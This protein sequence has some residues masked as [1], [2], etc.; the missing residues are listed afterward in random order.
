MAGFVAY[1]S[2]EPIGVFYEQKLADPALM[3]VRLIIV[4]RHIYVST[5]IGVAY[6][7]DDDRAFNW[8]TAIAL[9]GLA[10]SLFGNW[11]QYQ[12]VLDK[13][14][15]LAQAQTQIAQAQVKIDASLQEARHRQDALDAKR[16]SLE[17]QM[18]S[19]DSKIAEADFDAHRGAS[20]IAYA[21]RDQKPLALQILKDGMARKEELLKDKQRLQDKIDALPTN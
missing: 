15:E 13:K 5:G 16:R 17:S 9:G 8:Q 2:E 6:M 11:I 21:P 10:V 20:G 18:E 12:T 14:T 19:L 1:V 7:A 4:G 3:R